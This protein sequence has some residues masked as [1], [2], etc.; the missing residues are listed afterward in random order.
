MAMTRV[1]I[2]YT[3]KGGDPPL[4]IGSK[5]RFTIGSDKVDFVVTSMYKDSNACRLAYVDDVHG[6]SVTCVLPQEQV[7]KR[8]TGVSLTEDEVKDLEKHTFNSY[9]LINL[10]P[11]DLLRDAP[12]STEILRV[13]FSSNKSYAT[14]LV[15]DLVSELNNHK[16]KLEPGILALLS[17]EDQD[18]TPNEL[19]QLLGSYHQVLAKA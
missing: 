5:A 2:V 17:K 8:L 6:K 19:E 13:F 7:I 9:N 18:F 11:L 12:D 10:S 14:N 4:Q 1:N 16:D 15:K 3:H